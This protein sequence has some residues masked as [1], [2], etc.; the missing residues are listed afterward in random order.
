MQ[1]F[2]SRSLAFM[3]L[4]QVEKTLSICLYQQ[5]RSLVEKGVIVSLDESQGDHDKPDL[6]G[7]LL[8][9]IKIPEVFLP[10]S[11]RSPSYEEP[12]PL[13]SY[14]EAPS[15]LSSDAPVIKEV[16]GQPLALKKYFSL[17]ST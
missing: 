5:T 17:I 16:L 6:R 13:L 12:P 9:G 8:V 10:R 2:E 15:R 7:L 3:G 1:V 14:V 11:C 4:H